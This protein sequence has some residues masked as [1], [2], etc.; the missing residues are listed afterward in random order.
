M[1][2]R[3]WIHLSKGTVPRQAHVNVVEESGLIEDE[4]GRQG[5]AGRVAELYRREEPIA[6]TRSEGNLRQWDLVGNDL[7][8]SDF[9]DPGGV[10]LPIFYNQDIV[11][12]VS[13]RTAAMSYAMRNVTGDELYFVHRGTGIFETEF[14]DIPY[15]PGDWVL[16]PKGMTYRVIPDGAEN[17]MLIAETPDEMGLSD[18]GPIG[19]HAPYDPALLFVP[20]PRKKPATL[21]APRAGQEFEVR[22]K[23]GSEYSSFYYPFDIINDVEGWKG[24]LFPLKINIR[25]YR[26]IM[27]DRIHLMPTAYRIFETA[28][29]FVCNVLPRPAERDREAE[30]I[31]PYHRNVDFDE[32]LFAHGGTI[33]GAAIEPASITLVPQGM[34][35]GL[36]QDFQK[37]VRKT[38]SENDRFSGE[39][40]MFDTRRP[41]TVTEEAK[42]ASRTVNQFRQAQVSEDA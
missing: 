15:E 17:Y 25:D 33:L 32:V 5:F 21:D 36:A 38:W 20:E 41:L 8:P 22:L 6:W 34:H 9:Q 19:R 39:L 16:L 40:I 30:R 28:G 31:P 29:V 26:P 4:L 11:L 23:H 37:E 14:G 18:L 24:D 35:H 2:M 12:S 3:S 13:R 42:A 10:P 7:E 27:S 1:A